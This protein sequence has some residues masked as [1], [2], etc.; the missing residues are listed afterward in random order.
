MSLNGI[1]IFCQM[2]VW[3]CLLAVSV[4]LDDIPV[5]S[6][7]YNSLLLNFLVNSFAILEMR[8]V[9]YIVGEKKRKQNLKN[10]CI[11]GF[12]FFSVS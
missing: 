8:S 9:N 2:A 4:V 7:G 1:S 3:W 5:F 10:Y 11:K 6:P 12:S